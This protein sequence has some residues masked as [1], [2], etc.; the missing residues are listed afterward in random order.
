MVYMNF[1]LAFD[2]KSERILKFCEYTT[3]KSERQAIS[4]I[5]QRFHRYHLRDMTIQP[6]ESPRR[7]QDKLL[8]LSFRF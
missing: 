6:L 3:A 2:K 4:N 5:R 1:D 7:H 8:R